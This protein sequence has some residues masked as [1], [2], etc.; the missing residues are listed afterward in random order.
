MLPVGN[1]PILEHVI[2]ALHHAEVHDVT[3]VVGYKAAA[4][5][6][7][8]Q[9]GGRFGVQIRYAN[10]PDRR[11]TADAVA[12]GLAVC[13]TDE[14]VLIIPGD[15]YLGTEVLENFLRAAGD[16]DALLYTTT[17]DP[18]AYGV[19][20][21]NDD[22]VVKITEKP[23][24]AAQNTISTG[25]A[26]LSGDTLRGFKSPLQDQ[27]AG[28]PEALNKVARSK[29]RLRAIPLEGAWYDVDRPENLLGANALQLSG[30]QG[31]VEGTVEPGASIVGDVRI[32]PGTRI[33]SGTYIVGPVLIGSGCEIGPQTVIYGPTSI[34]DNV[35]IGPFT[36]LLECVVLADCRIA[37]GCTLHHAVLD[38]GV[39]LAPRVTIDKAH[40][41]AGADF[42]AIVGDG[43]VLG[44]NV[45]IQPGSTVGANARVA[46]HKT[47]ATVPD[48]A[49]VV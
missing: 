17:Q 37:S 2:A 23:R 29:G 19:V 25:I 40:A 8:F 14:D 42:G 22:W 34:G 36:E 20:E 26:K 47:I 3:I 13:G 43:T 1:R 31:H 33:R 11:G 9:D 30:T 7:H 4:I 45:V 5:Q 24:S 32:G 10:Q 48:G 38:R 18:R 41:V 39:V 6:T 21:L 46:P 49:R 44:N 12:R 15:N 27:A 16:H 35:S 28:L